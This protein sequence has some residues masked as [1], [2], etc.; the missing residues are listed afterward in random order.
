MF[1]LGINLGILL[2]GD[3][4]VMHYYNTII[5]IFCSFRFKRDLSM[6]SCLGEKSPLTI[7]FSYKQIIAL[8]CNKHRHWRSSLRIRQ[9]K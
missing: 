8:I 6:K 3:A 2:N 1:M 5:P 9:K 7:L 4:F